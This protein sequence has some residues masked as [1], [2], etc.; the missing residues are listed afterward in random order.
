MIDFA[1]PI[2]LAHEADFALGPLT[3]RPS[4]REVVRDGAVEVLEPRVMQVLVALHR[5]GGGIVSRDDLTRCCWSGRIVGEDAINRVISRL[6]R[7]A[8]GIGAQAFRIE[9]VTKVGY[10]LVPS[11][12]T[13]ETPAK[14]EP[15]PPPPQP[16]SR[17]GVLAAGATM[18]VVA[19]AGA[20]WWWTSRSQA[21]APPPGVAALMTQAEHAM[22]QDT[23]EGQNQAIGLYQQVTANEP[24]YADGWGSLAVAYACSASHR[25]AS[26]TATLLHRARAAAAERASRRASR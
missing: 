20:G 11:A 9:T 13:V 3:V 8:E 1:D 14:I 21:S 17:R 10:R 5:A 22:A 12:C 16:P 24:G 23:R 26:E 7:T 15:A 2:A 4:T 25:A 6:R 19:L 18:A